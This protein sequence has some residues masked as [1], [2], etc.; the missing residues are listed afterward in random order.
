MKARYEEVAIR[1]SRNFPGLGESRLERSIDGVWGDTDGGLIPDILAIKEVVCS[2]DDT[3]R[4]TEAFSNRIASIFG[5]CGVRLNAVGWRYANRGA[6]PDVVAVQERVGVKDV[7]ASDSKLDAQRI[8]CISGAA[9][10][11]LNACWVGWRS[12]HRWNA[13]RSPLPDCRA[14]NKAIGVLHV[15]SGD[16]EDG[17][18]ISTSHFVWSGI[19]SC[20][21]WR[22][23]SVGGSGREGERWASFNWASRSRSW[24]RYGCIHVDEVLA[25]TVLEGIT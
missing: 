22:R 17:G 19:G 12:D 11:G 2:V 16:S 4:H 14:I 3:A 15:I 24:W 5:A 23:R 6:N 8:A 25:T 18:D 10:I 1:A 7:D 13:K 21:R 9:S 20:A